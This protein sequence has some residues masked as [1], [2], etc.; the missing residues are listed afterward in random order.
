MSLPV[1]SLNNRTALVT[2]S[3]GG[4]GKAIALAFAEAGADVAVCDMVIEDGQLEAV[5]RRIRETGRCSIAVQADIS[6]KAHVDSMVQKVVD[7]FG[8]IDILVNNAAVRARLPLLDLAEEDWDR[9]M[10]TDLK[11]YFLCCQAVG[12]RM[13]EQKRGNI[14]SMASRAGMV[15]GQQKGNVYS[16]AKAGVIMLTR[17]LAQDLAGNNVRVNAIAPATVVTDAT[18]YRWSNSDLLE[19]YVKSI[20]L[21]R[22][23]ET[24]DVVGLALF[25]ASDVSSYITGQTI[26]LDG[27]SLA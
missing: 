15:V 14:I 22:L 20:P 8:H 24:D 26:A 1:L 5:A 7:E 16:I 23:A 12:R 18:Q 10:D 11:G 13:V 21:G 17:V 9:V 6:K 4:I 25:L 19:Q 2:G 27:G 3:R